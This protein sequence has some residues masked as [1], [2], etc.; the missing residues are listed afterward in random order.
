MKPVL[1]YLHKKVVVGITTVHILCKLSAIAQFANLRA[2]RY[3]KQL[4]CMLETFRMRCLRLFPWHAPLCRPRRI[5]GPTV[6]A[7][8]A[9]APPWRPWPRSPSKKCTSVEKIHCHADNREAKAGAL[10]RFPHDVRTKA[11]SAHPSKRTQSNLLEISNIP[12]TFESSPSTC[13]LANSP[14]AS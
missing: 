3:C 4:I 14:A 8:P 6:A 2:P 13:A 7:Y 5:D 10:L 12:S 1:P 11:K 9:A